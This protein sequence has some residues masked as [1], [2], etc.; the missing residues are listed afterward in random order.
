MILGLGH[1]HHGSGSNSSEQMGH[2]LGWQWLED[3]L[4]Y[5]IG[6]VLSDFGHRPTPAGRPGISAEDGWTVD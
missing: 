6:E 2:C 1:V 5:G 4:A 3:S